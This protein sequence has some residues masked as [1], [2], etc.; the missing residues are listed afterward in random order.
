M[1]GTM[2]FCDISGFTALSERLA[3]KG[4]VGSE[5]VAAALTTVFSD[6]LDIAI[7]R[8][9]DLLKFGGDA[10]LLLFTGSDHCVR[11]ASAAFEMKR[12]LNTSGRIDTG[13]GRVDLD[14]TVGVHTGS[15]DLFLVGDRHRELIVAGPDA[16]ATVR[17]E[18]SAQAGEIVVT[19]AA[20]RVLDASLL[21]ASSDGRKLLAFPPDAP[22]VTPPELESSAQDLGQYLPTALRSVVGTP[23]GEGEH[24][25]A[26]VAFLKFKGLDGE[27]AAGM[28][29]KVGDQLDATVRIVQAAADEYGVTFLASDIDVDGGKII[30]IAGAPATSD[31]DTERLLRT[32]R[33]IT[34]ADPPLALKIGVNAGT[35]F[36][37]DVGSIARAA[38]TVIGDAVNLAARVMVQAEPGQVLAEA[39]VLERSETVFDT[40]DIEP[41][42]VKGKEAAV[43]AV[44]V[45][46]AQ[47]TRELESREELPFSGRVQTLADVVGKFSDLSES[48]G[49]VA[50]ILGPAGIGK[51]RLLGEA[52]NQTDPGAWFKVGCERYEASTPY[53]SL[54]TLLKELLVIPAGADAVEAGQRLTAA[55][56]DKQPDLLPWLPLIAVPLGAEVDPTAETEALADR[57]RKE[58]TQE[59]TLELLAALL[60]APAALVFD[61][62]QWLDDSTQE[63]LDRAGANTDRFP[64]LICLAGRTAPRAIPEETARIELQPLDSEEGLAL[65]RAVAADNPVPHHRLIEAVERSGGSPLFLISLVEA[66]IEGGE[67]PANVEDL[68]N[69]RIDRLAPGTRKVLRYASV[70]GRHFRPEILAASIGDEVPEAD[71][72]GIWD[73]LAD[74]IEPAEGGLRFREN[75]YQDVA[76]AGLPFHVRKDLHLRVG[77]ALES[78]SEHANPPLLSLHYSLGE[79][80]PRAWQYSVEAGDAAAAEYAHVDAADLYQRALR[81][82]PRVPDL[83][84]A[85]LARVNEALGTSSELAGLYDDAD[86]AFAATRKYLPDDPIAMGRVLGKQGLL[87]ER[88][89][90]Y[91]VALRWLT[92][93]LNT[94]E[95]AGQTT[96]AIEEE[97]EL[98]LAYAGV[99]YRQGH[100]HH[101]VRRC[102][103]ALD[104]PGLSPEKEA[105]ARYLLCLAYAHLADSRSQQEG[106]RALQA[107]EEIGDLL[108]KANVLNN[109]GMNAYYRG[110]WD[111]ALGYWSDSRAAREA[112]GDIIG[113]ATQT[114]NLGEIY[115][116]QGKWDKARECFAEALQ[117][118]QGARYGVGV[119][120]ASSNLGRVEARA[121]HPTEATRWLAAGVEGFEEIGAGAFV[122]ETN[123]R[124]AENLVLAGDGGAEAKTRELIK[125]AEDTLGAAV[126]EATL[127]RILGYALWQGEDEEGAANA[128]RLSL[129][130]ADKAGAP[131]EEGLTR[132]ALADLTGDK[133]EA[134]AA[135]EIFERMG[136]ICTP[137]I[138]VP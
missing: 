44:V 55:V 117:I 41:F 47:G 39:G 2:V 123:V 69:A 81:S 12:K 79:D 8:G 85:Q 133:S 16:S 14:M 33:T 135:N 67:L 128:F 5:E 42:L 11:G 98:I 112:C 29:E 129:A 1:P 88:S 3:K 76:Y 37:G 9:G 21:A 32:V 4:R 64:W 63:T 131:Y 23:S 106:E 126:L 38:Y 27:I 125:I 102:E 121:N 52:R 17:A 18:E 90:N 95:Q 91:S 77:R 89:G 61:N 59:A 22:A 25:R 127:Y 83:A 109:L 26:V 105:H 13:S 96:E 115:S 124:V 60:P 101:C 113:A 31:N 116:D 132:H 120:L 114:N 80:H 57:F 43:E 134:S 94:L 19:E 65:A 97:A 66:S 82:A 110:E 6:L 108:G 53:H 71:D 73:R 119:A 70:I 30:L 75:L 72:P 68:I 34:E 93:G 111:G 84:T 49:T 20:G 104:L 118:W 7:G 138:P 56:E 36:A 107:F 10:L 62:A 58:R 130:K 40:S 28:A 103:Q 48:G 99:R 87:R 100:Y 92:R 74:Y 54:R 86:A 136:V 15:F 137:E 51:S 24:R 122:L 35:L 50:W 46:P 78:H 45:G